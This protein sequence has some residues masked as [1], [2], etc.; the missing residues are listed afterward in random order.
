MPMILAIDP[1]SRNI[2]HAI[3]DS[4]TRTLMDFGHD[5]LGGA[6]KIQRLKAARAYIHALLPEGCNVDVCAVERMF[7]TLSGADFCLHVVSYF[8]QARC[9]DLGVLCQEI[10]AGTAKKAATG[11]GNAR[12]AE[13]RVALEA[14]F[15]AA[16]TED[17]SDAVSVALAA[18]QLHIC[19]G[20]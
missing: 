1:G 17:E 11:H 19:N 15:G 2:A 7:S 13:V 18:A 8:V 16:L 10:S 9:E 4:D 6:N 3:Y 12:K 14:M 20:A 5:T